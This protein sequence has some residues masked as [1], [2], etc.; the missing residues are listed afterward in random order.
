MSS[1]VIGD[2]VV[3]SKWIIHGNDLRRSV[4]YLQQ[5]VAQLATHFDSVVQ[6]P[7]C[8]DLRCVQ[9]LLKSFCPSIL[10]PSIPRQ[11]GTRTLLTMSQSTYRATHDIFKPILP[12][13]LLTIVIWVDEEKLCAETL[14][15]SQ[16]MAAFHGADF[17]F[18]LFHEKRLTLN[19]ARAAELDGG[20][21]VNMKTAQSE[22]IGCQEDPAVYQV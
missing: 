17:R 15:D 7:V 10:C 11:G 12:F 18:S 6:L 2:N 16:Y 3:G 19:L 14:D 1:K 4:Q 21:L 8:H 20:I 5:L 13:G 9:N 22:P